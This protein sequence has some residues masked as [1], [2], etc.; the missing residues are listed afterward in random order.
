MKP[1]ITLCYKKQLAFV[2]I[3][4]FSFHATLEEAQKQILEKLNTIGLPV[5]VAF[6]EINNTQF[7]API[8]AAIVSFSGD[9]PPESLIS[10]NSSP[11]QDISYTFKGLIEYCSACNK[12]GHVYCNFKPPKYESL[13][14]LLPPTNGH[15][16]GDL[17]ASPLSALKD[18]G[19]AVPLYYHKGSK[20][21]KFKQSTSQTLP[22][23][24][25]YA[26]LPDT[27]LAGIASNGVLKETYTTQE[28]RELKEKYD[29]LFKSYATL[30]SPNFH[31]TLI[32]NPQIQPREGSKKSHAASGGSPN[33]AGKKRGRPR[34]EPSGDERPKMSIKPLTNCMPLQKP[35][36]HPHDLNPGMGETSVFQAVTTS[37]TA[38]LPASTPSLTSAPPAF[39]APN[40]SG[41]VSSG[42]PDQP[43]KR[44]RPRKVP[45]DGTPGENPK[46]A[47]RAN[48]AS[49]MTA[50]PIQFV[51]SGLE[52]KF[53]EST[54]DA[55]MQSM[56]TSA[57][58]PGSTPFVTSASFIPS[59]PMPASGSFTSNVTT[60]TTPSNMPNATSGSFT[61][62][63]ALSSSGPFSPNASLSQD[64]TTQ[65]PVTSQF[66]GSYTT[67]S[68]SQSDA[69]SS[70]IYASAPLSS[71]EA[72]TSLAFSSA[73]V[74]Q[75]DALSSMASMNPF[76]AADSSVDFLS[77]SFMFM[78]QTTMDT[79]SMTI[80]QMNVG[81]TSVPSSQPLDFI[82][83]SQSNNQSI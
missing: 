1:I 29:A 26:D 58:F 36:D 13:D 83:A 35:Q 45:G 71:S 75:T 14:Q 2:I 82:P 27:R 65:P 77:P 17:Q 18:Q 42:A 22:L 50:A 16:A 19:T 15:G 25:M 10:T 5:K 60:S 56:I 39:V 63:A 74:S 11:H 76:S 69:L 32:G 72:L 3:K 48:K 43:R 24:D 30:L 41:V 44:G 6:L 62:D 9:K 7:L 53:N 81:L 61:P 64:A 54:T 49:K 73:P 80:P 52:A 34:K 66:A 68:A 57:S 4:D 51:T 20:Q 67:A 28:Y 46:R 47:P 40:A 79:S 23:S 59:V 12:L 33:S 38:C 70:M 8:A 55:Q 31:E 21:N 78:P 37:P